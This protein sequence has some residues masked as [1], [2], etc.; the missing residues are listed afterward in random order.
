MPVSA[1]ALAER[2]RAEIIRDY[3][4]KLVTRLRAE[5]ATI[6]L[7]NRISL[8]RRRNRAEAYNDIADELEAE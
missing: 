7:S 1:S 3:R 6:C 8:V 2:I 5:A 4:E